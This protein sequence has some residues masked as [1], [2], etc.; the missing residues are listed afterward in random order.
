[1]VRKSEWRRLALRVVPALALAML[2]LLPAISAQADDQGSTMIQVESP[3]SDTP[4]STR[5]MVSGWA[6]DPTGD[7]AGVDM[8]RMYL[9]DPNA[10]GQDLGAA[11]YGQSRPDVAHTLGDSRFTNSGFQLAVELPAGDYTLTIYAHRNTAS[12]DDGWVVYSTSFTASASVRPDPRAAA[13]LGG[14]QPQVRTANPGNGGSGAILAGGGGNRGSGDVPFSINSP[15]GSQIR[16]TVSNQN[17]PIPLEPI[18]PGAAS[19]T[20]TGSN[21]PELA[22]PTGS[23][24]N[25]RVSVA[26]DTNLPGG[27]G[28]RTGQVSMV[29]GQGNQCPGQNCPS[30][31]TNMNQQ[32]Q[33]MTPDMIR[34]ITGYNIPGLGNA[35]PCTPTNTP[36]APGGCNGVTGSSL[37]PGQPTALQQLQAQNQAAL[38]ASGN[39]PVMQPVN[40]TAPPCMAYGSNGQCTA[41]AGSV[42][43]MGSTCLRFVGTQC[44]YYGQPPPQAAPAPGQA[45]N[46]LPG[47]PLTGLP[48][49]PLPGQPGLAGAGTANPL[50]QA[51]P[52]GSGCAQWGSAGCMQPAGGAGANSNGFIPGLAL[53][54]PSG[55]LTPGGSGA[56]GGTLQN[57]SLPLAT[58]TQSSI[59]QTSTTA[60][61]G[62]TNPATSPYGTMPLPSTAGATG[63]NG[64]C[65]QFGPGGS[66]VRSQ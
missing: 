50:Q 63:G 40:G 33:N 53:T 10:D 22:D 5:L 35:T 11:T 58:N 28:Y 27:S 12:P 25:I 37:A 45:P 55:V 6:A 42:G 20:M 51:S 57:A 1:V 34:Q 4:S 9:G 2:G 26:S 48:G 54:Y 17:D 30:N 13:L 61:A 32:L 19:A 18:I 14:D 47:Q 31:V 38:T 23:G 56:T 24:A 36:N 60:V 46:G 44:S 43:P 41:Q 3:S 65:L 16:S 29:G 59:Y 7:G 49:Q 66:C 21:S 62:A 15:D 8:V 64:M 39:Q 52:G